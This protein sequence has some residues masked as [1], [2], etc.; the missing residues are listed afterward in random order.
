MPGEKK[1]KRLK[2]FKFRSWSFSD[3]MAVKGLIT[4]ATLFV[5]ECGKKMKW[6]RQMRR[7]F[8]KGLHFWQ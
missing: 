3:D 4:H 2:G 6:N 7:K 1:T 8:K 5:G